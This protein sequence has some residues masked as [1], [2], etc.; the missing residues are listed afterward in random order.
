MTWSREEATAKRGEEVLYQQA[1]ELEL[2]SERK[3]GWNGEWTDL[4]SPR[5]MSGRICHWGVR[6]FQRLQVADTSRV[7]DEVGYEVSSLIQDVFIIHGR[8]IQPRP[9][10][11]EMSS[12]Y[13]C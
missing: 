10:L 8:T 9:K 11:T 4:S 7:L 2:D 5:D 6:P 12:G 3:M 13:V 1:V